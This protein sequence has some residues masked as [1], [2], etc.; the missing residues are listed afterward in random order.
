MEDGDPVAFS[1]KKTDDM[2]CFRL[3]V[4]DIESKIIVDGDH[5]DSPGGKYR[6]I[7]DFKLLGHERKCIY[8]FFSPTEK[9]IGSLRIQKGKLDVVGG[10]VQIPFRPG[11]DVDSVFH[12]LRLALISAIASTNGLVLPSAT[13]SSPSLTRS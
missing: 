10:F 4:N 1:V 9:R 6:I 12:L 13:S 5:S 11:R 2:D 8:F 7:Y 3:I